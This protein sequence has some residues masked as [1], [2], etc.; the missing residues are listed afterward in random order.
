VDLVIESPV[1]PPPSGGPPVAP[2]PDPRARVIDPPPDPAARHQFACRDCGSPLHADQ[3]ACLACGAMVE[4]PDDRIGLRRVVA[5]SSAALLLLGGAVGAA[6]AGLPNGKHVGKGPI[7]QVLGKKPAPPIPPATVTPAPSSGGGLGK[8]APLAGSSNTPTKPPP[9][10]KSSTPA[11]K[12]TSHKSSSSG[13][14]GGSSSSNSGTKPKKKHPKPKPKSKPSLTLFT[15][16][17]APTKAGIL[18]GS[19]HSGSATNVIDGDPNSFWSAAKS[20]AG[21]WVETNSP[22]Y[23]KLGVVSSTPGYS[24]T[25]YYANGTAPSSKH[26][27]TQA[28]AP[29]T[30]AKKKQTFALTSAAQSADYYLLVINS[31]SHVKINEIQLLR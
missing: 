9:I 8:S 17:E 5:G 30:S 6:V 1:K 22:P 7:A 20:G 28:G 2:P 31:G 14:S 24:A 10:H 13:G 11:K 19:G 4:N 27:W 15:A 16:G 18:T 26:G 12:A 29:I 21:V 3:A 23:A 25:V